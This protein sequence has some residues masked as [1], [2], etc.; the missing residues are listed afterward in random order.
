[1]YLPILTATIDIHELAD[2]DTLENRYRILLA[3]QG[4]FAS[5]EQ[6]KTAIITA[7][8]RKQSQVL[9]RHPARKVNSANKA[10]HLRVAK[11]WNDLP[12]IIRSLDDHLMISKK[13]WSVLLV[14]SIILL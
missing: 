8:T 14:L 5:R 4:F 2:I 9:L 10:L 7:N 13:S 11:S 3:K 6:S 1:M 12:V